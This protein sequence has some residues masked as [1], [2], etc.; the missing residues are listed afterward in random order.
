MEQRASD[1]QHMPVRILCGSDFFFIL[2]LSTMLLVRPIFPILFEL[3]F[4]LCWRHALFDGS[5]RFYSLNRILHAK[6]W[7][8]S[9]DIF[10]VIN[11][12]FICTFVPLLKSPQPQSVHPGLDYDSDT[13]HTPNHSSFLRLCL[14]LGRIF[15]LCI[16]K[17]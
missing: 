15:P 3:R 13:L 9:R 7:N 12:S 10:S 16:S 2:R 5:D 8:L 17:I 4:V 14:S 1:H 11:I 6:R